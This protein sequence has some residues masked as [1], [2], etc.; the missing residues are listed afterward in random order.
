MTTF[1]LGYLRADARPAPIED[2]PTLCGGQLSLFT[3]Y[4]FCALFPRAVAGGRERSGSP[5][6]HSAAQFA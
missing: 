2:P 4:A 1:Y 3:F 5:L 6:A